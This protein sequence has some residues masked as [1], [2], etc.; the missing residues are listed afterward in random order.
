MTLFL[1][2]GILKDFFL[3]SS[4]KYFIFYCSPTLSLGVMVWKSS[5]STNFAFL[6]QWFLRVFK[7]ATIFP[8]FLNNLPFKKGVPFIWI[9]LIPFIKFGWNW[10][11][12]FGKVENLFVKFTKRRTLY[13][14]I[15][16]RWTKWNIC[17]TLIFFTYRF[18]DHGIKSTESTGG[19]GV[20]FLNGLIVT[21][22]VNDKPIYIIIVYTLTE[23]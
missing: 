3:I 22:K 2:K 20:I 5:M 18:Y 10:P 17:M 6:V 12:G 21:L 1:R 11:C 4:C 14:N 9:I 23:D 8:L 13:L 19:W 16:Y 7:D 15:W